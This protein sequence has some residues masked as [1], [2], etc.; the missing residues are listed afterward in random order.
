MEPLPM[1][2]G[3]YFG[4]DSQQDDLSNAGCSGIYHQ[5]RR[6]SPWNRF[7]PHGEEPRSANEWELVMAGGDI[8]T[9]SEPSVEIEVEIGEDLLH[10][11]YSSSRNDTSTED[12]LGLWYAHGILEKMHG[13]TNVLLQ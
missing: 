6:L 10:L 13:H 9:M 2:V 1:N 12:V 7:S 11:L 4:V 5:D 8:D 3:D